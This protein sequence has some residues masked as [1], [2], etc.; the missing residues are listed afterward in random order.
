M[1]QAIHYKTHNII[2]R[3]TSYFVSIILSIDYKLYEM[4]MCFD[5]NI[6]SL[7][8]FKFIM[9]LTEAQN[10]LEIYLNDDFT[11]SLFI[12]A[13][14]CCFKHF[15]LNSKDEQEETIKIDFKDIE[16]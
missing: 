14:D 1:K 15:S 13:P 12:P 16:S 10:K 2:Y 3:D 6:T 11:G 8:P 5:L 7:T 4:R 9:N